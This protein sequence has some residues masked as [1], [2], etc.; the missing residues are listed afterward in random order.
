M[1]DDLRKYTCLGTPKYYYELLTTLNDSSSNRWNISDIEQLLYNRVFDDRPIIDGGIDLGLR[2]NVL[3]L[4]DEAISMNSD[5]ENHLNSINQM[6]DMFNHYLFNSLKTDTSFLNIFSSKN[7]SYDIIYKSL[8]LDNSAFGFK[9]SNFKQLLIDFNSISK[10]PTPQFNSYI[11]NQRYKKLFDKAVLPEIKKRKI[12]VDEFKRSMEQKQIYGE[13][14]E[15]FILEYEKQR[16]EGQKE[17]DWIAEYIVNEGY[18]IASYN[19]VVDKIPNRFIEVKSYEGKAPYFYWSKN[20][21]RVARKKGV[22]YW[23]YLVNRN[24][25]KNVDYSPIKIQNPYESILNNDQWVKV[26]DKYWIKANV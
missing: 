12:G 10:H 3:Q 16:L 26:V 17:I 8:Q 20:E 19:N 1:L 5:F 24:E 22:E 11:I 21:Y 23:I 9:Y 15:K 18:D 4:N 6:I 7:L 25:I 13:E 14:A 2:L